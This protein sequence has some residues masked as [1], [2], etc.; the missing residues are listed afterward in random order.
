MSIYLGKEVLVNVCISY[1]KVLPKYFNMKDLFSS[2]DIVHIRYSLTDFTIACG[3]MIWYRFEK[4]VEEGD[5]FGEVGLVMDKRRSAS[6][7]AL[8]NSEVCKLN[9]K[10]FF[11]TLN[12]YP[13]DAIE[14]LIT[15][16]YSS[17]HFCSGGGDG[18][19]N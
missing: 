19:F 15:G 16:I 7:R 14:V 6:C 8:T 10:E 5:Y 1:L 12:M 2:M 4:Q 18:R 9:K 13:R 17:L 3:G 11:E